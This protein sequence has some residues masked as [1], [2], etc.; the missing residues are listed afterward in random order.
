[1]EIQP[2]VDGGVEAMLRITVHDDTA[3]PTFQL[4]G[5]LAGSCVAE[6]EDCGRA[7]GRPA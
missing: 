3:S 1:M 2:E 5:A 4:E 7:L 6:R